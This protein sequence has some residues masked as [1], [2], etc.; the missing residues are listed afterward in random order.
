MQWYKILGGIGAVMFVCSLCLFGYLFYTWP[1]QHPVSLQDLLIDPELFPPGWETR[2][3]GGRTWEHIPDR[4]V[5]EEYRALEGV[6]RTIEQKGS[7]VVVWHRVLRYQ[8]QFQ[9]AK[10]FMI[11]LPRGF[12]G[13]SWYIPRD[14]NYH[15]WSAD[16]FRFACTYTKARKQFL[17]SAMAQDGEIISIVWIYVNQ[18]N[19]RQLQDIE[20]IIDSIDRTLDFRLTR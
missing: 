20:Y 2:L 5:R 14:W 4:A 10:A 17:C 9:A 16:R 8:N 1:V 12:P 11:D 18:L 13:N 6:M 7:H 15:N 3:Y 19:L